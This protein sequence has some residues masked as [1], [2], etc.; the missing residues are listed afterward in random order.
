MFHSCKEVVITY[1]PKRR[2]RAHN[3]MSPSDFE[4][5][6]TEVRKAATIMI[7]VSRFERVDTAK[8]PMS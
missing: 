5:Y 6:T 4:R 3:G 7:E 2:R 1:N 8:T